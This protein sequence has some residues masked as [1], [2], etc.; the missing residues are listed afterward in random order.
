MGKGLVVSEKEN[1]K[2]YYVI[3][4]YYACIC[5]FFYSYVHHHILSLW[6]KY[7]VIISMI[8][9]LC[10]IPLPPPQES[11]DE[12]ILH[13]P[14]WTLL[15]KQNK[16]TQNLIYLKPFMTLKIKLTLIKLQNHSLKFTIL[17]FITDLK[18]S[19]IS[20]RADEIFQILCVS[21]VLS[22]IHAR[23]VVYFWA[24]LSITK[25]FYLLLLDL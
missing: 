23:P 1:F 6:E 12:V 18:N 4:S 25:M 3:I 5:N 7:R 9:V 10:N 24:T 22:F 21:M 2:Q 13:Q 19:L 11:K 17:N 8:W 16:S 14:K 20:T 15:R